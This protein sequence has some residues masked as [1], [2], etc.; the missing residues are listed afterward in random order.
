MS[1]VTNGPGG[2]HVI[3]NKL[4]TQAGVAGCHSFVDSTKAAF[5]EVNNGVV[6]SGES[7]G[8]LEDADQ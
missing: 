1:F 2:H 3:G 8:E 5:T 6:V 4:S 7:I